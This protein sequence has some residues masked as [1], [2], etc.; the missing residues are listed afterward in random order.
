MTMFSPALKTI[1]IVQYVNGEPL[2]ITDRQPV[3]F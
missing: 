2:T 3:L 1:L